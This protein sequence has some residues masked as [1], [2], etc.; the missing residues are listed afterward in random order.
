MLH[1]RLPGAVVD[2]VDEPQLFVTDIEGAEGISF[3]AASAAH[4]S[5]VQP[6]TVCV[7]V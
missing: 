6:L 5:L 4:A 1:N 2:K 7:R 3:G